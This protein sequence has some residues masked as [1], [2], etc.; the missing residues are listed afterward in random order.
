MT[1]A[2]VRRA[3]AAADLRRDDAGRRAQ[4]EPGQKQHQFRGDVAHPTHWAPPDA[5]GD[6]LALAWR[7]DAAPPR[8]IRVRP[9][10]R[11]RMLAQMNPADR[12]L[13]EERGTIGRPPGVPLVVD[14]SLPLFP[15]FEIVRA[16]P[17]SA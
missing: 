11:D 1:R 17:R 15:G 5:A 14:G 3:P 4:R 7:P 10:L 6:I 9:E 12:A 8:E 13:A 16:R 2:A